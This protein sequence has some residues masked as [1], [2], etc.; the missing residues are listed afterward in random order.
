MILI[1]AGERSHAALQMGLTD[2]VTIS[3]CERHRIRRLFT[4]DRRDLGAYLKGKTPRSRCSLRVAPDRPC[5]V[6]Q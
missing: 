5:F 3:L 1:D 6:L 2:A 4:F